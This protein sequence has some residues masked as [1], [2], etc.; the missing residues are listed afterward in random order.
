M[1]GAGSGTSKARASLSRPMMAA[2]SSAARDAVC[3]SGR[4]S[5]RGLGSAKIQTLRGL[6]RAGL[7]R[8]RD[9]DYPKEWVPTELGKAVAQKAG[10]ST[11]FAGEVPTERARAFIL[12]GLSLPDVWASGERDA[13][14]PKRLQPSAARNARWIEELGYGTFQNGRDPRYGSGYSILT[15]SPKGQALVEATDTP[16]TVRLSSE[17]ESNLRAGRMKYAIVPDPCVATLANF[18]ISSSD[19]LN[20]PRA[21]YA[22]LYD[23]GALFPGTAVRLVSASGGKRIATANAG[24]WNRIHLSLMEA[25]SKG[26]KRVGWHFDATFEYPDETAHDQDARR[27]WAPFPEDYEFEA[28]RPK[29]DAVQFAQDCGFDSLRS[30]RSTWI[31]RAEQG[32]ATAGSG[33]RG[34]IKGI[35][36]TLEDV[37]LPEK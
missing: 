31:K 14:M 13:H 21:L 30:M 24:D 10:L 11:E 33:M 26:K 32:A 8:L 12:R 35:I 27:V 6:E 2:L 3:E 20:S 15:L 34:W 28:V 16:V 18:Q 4:V 9:S 29:A 17:E 19:W 7:L 22:R 23:P 25:Y 37:Q 36:V 5:R 1:L